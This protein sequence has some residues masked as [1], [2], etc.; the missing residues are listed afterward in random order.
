MSTESANPQPQQGAQFPQSR[1]RRLRYNPAV[2]QLCQH[3]RLHAGSL[4]LP[5]FVRNGTAIRDEISSMPGQFQLS[6]DQL[7]AEAQEVQNLGIGG[8][9]LFGIPDSKDSQGTAAL[10]DNGI[11][12]QAIAA[13]KDVTPDLLVMTDIC[14]CEYTDH[15][16]CGILHDKTGIMDVDNDATLKLLG[17]QAV[18][19][20][21]QGADIIAPSGMMDGMVQAIRSAMDQASFQHV[22]IM[23][24]S[25]KYNSAY[26]G[27]FRDAAESAPQFGDR[28]SYQM[29]PS[30][31]A[32]QALRE[33]QLD[34]Q[35]GADF[36]MVKPALA[37]LDIITRVRQA[38]PGVPLA[39]YN[40]SG[41][42]SMVKAAAANGWI[43]ETA[44]VDETL[45]AMHRAGAD[46]LLTYWAKDVAQRL[47]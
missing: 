35:E 36:V 20:A 22:P 45:L 4:I 46:I 18:S 32:D 41:E 34:L 13:I 12:Q 44:V 14:M 15:G 39:A 43:N 24:Y 37:Y 5:L 23:S 1:M 29:D 42:Y 8:V 47:Q 26:Y 40:V 2:R 17:Q 9:I 7:A 6:L 3:T 27:P 19:H 28:R 10:H 11:V 38:F 31:L 33:V 21:Q 25:A 30:T 16:H